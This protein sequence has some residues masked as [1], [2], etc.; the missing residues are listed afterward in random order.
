MYDT[1]L[2]Y[3]TTLYVNAKGQCASIFELAYFALYASLF[4]SLFHILLYI[5]VTFSRRFSVGCQRCNHKL[6]DQN[7]KTKIPG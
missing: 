5:K 4:Y 2:S 7:K 6:Y 3:K 1:M